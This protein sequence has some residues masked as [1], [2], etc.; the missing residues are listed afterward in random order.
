MLRLL[1]ATG[2][3]ALS[4]HAQA[5]PRIDPVPGGIAEVLLAPAN[6]PRPQALLAGRPTLVIPGPHGWRALV[7]LPLDLPPGVRNLTVRLANGAERQLSFLVRPKDY[8]VQYLRFKDSSMVEPDPVTLAR[9]K[10]E[11]RTQ[12][13]VK[14]LWRDTPAVD[15]AFVAPAEGR[16]SSRFGLRRVMNDQPRAPHR[17]L[18]LALATGTPV[19]SPAAGVV[20]HVGDFFFNGKTVF[21]DHGQGLITMVCHLDQVAVA[22]GQE[23]GRGENLGRSGSSGRAT[24]PHLHWTVFLNGTA[25]DPELFLPPTR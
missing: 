25:V 16:R 19:R 23:V 9:I 18:D 5:A 3:W 2:L 20:T 12:D 6:A 10:A 17:G 22:A 11:Q 8:P 24:G 13:E 4:L 1:F 7:G 14:T 21:V 15:L